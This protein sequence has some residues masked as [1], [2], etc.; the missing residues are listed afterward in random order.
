MLGQVLVEQPGIADCGP[1]GT[2]REVASEERRGA[3]EG[4]V[5]RARGE[6]SGIGDVHVK[7]PQ[8]GRGGRLRLRGPPPAQLELHSSQLKQGAGQHLR[9]PPGGVRAEAAGVRP[10]QP[11]V[12]PQITKSG[13]DGG[14]GDAPPGQPIGHRWR[15][16]EVR[17]E[18]HRVRRGRQ[19]RPV[20]ETADA[21]RDLAACLIDCCPVGAGQSGQQ[22]P[23]VLDAPRIE[24]E[25]CGHV[26]VEDRVVHVGVTIEPPGRWRPHSGGSTA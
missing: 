4:G 21:G 9:Q 23:H 13:R 7:P 14:G 19:W 24:V 16:L 2:V 20:R 26:V 12:P 17:G 1:G 15:G 22:P 6:R 25:E 11:K 5:D 8:S 18:Q 3:I 10:M